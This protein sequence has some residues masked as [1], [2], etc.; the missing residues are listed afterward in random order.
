MSADGERPRSC[1]VMINGYDT[2]EAAY[3]RAAATA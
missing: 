1:G 3:A 2:R